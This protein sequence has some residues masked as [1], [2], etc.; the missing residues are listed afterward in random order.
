MR[1][2]T[3]GVSSTDR[4]QPV[5]LQHLDLFVTRV[6]N[7]A[8]VHLCTRI[9][10]PLSVPRETRENRGIE[11]QSQTIGDVAKHVETHCSLP[12]SCLEDAQETELRSPAD[13]SSTDQDPTVPHAVIGT[14]SNGGEEDCHDR[15]GDTVGD[16]NDRRDGLHAAGELLSDTIGDD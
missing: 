13:D 9:F 15:K 16:Q 3:V 5:P 6:I 7:L 14:R 1:E 2:L 11:D 12:L 8:T 10:R 4:T